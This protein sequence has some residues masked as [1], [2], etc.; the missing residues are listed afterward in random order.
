[1]NPTIFSFDWL[2]LTIHAALNEVMHFVELLGLHEGLEEQKHGMKGFQRVMYGQ[3]GFR[4]GFQ[5][6]ADRDY[7]TL[8]LPGKALDFVGPERL[9]TFYAQLCEAAVGGQLR[10]SVPRVDL[11]FDT[12]GFT[13]DDV[14][15]AR[16][17]DEVQCPAKLYDERVNYDG[18]QKVGH[19]LYF[20]SRTSATMLRVYR[21][22]DGSS[23]FGEAPF[24]RVEL[25]LKE[26]VATLAF[27]QVM[28][29]KMSDWITV[30]GGLL[31]GFFEIASDWW[32]KFVE[33]WPKALLK[34]ARSVSSVARVKEWLYTQVAASLATYLSAVS[35]LD[36]DIINSELAALTMHGLESL[37]PRHRAMIKGYQGAPYAPGY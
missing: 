4:L 21:K 17:A 8:F 32:K 27:M 33:S 25:E 36:H 30:A 23:L 1:M 13:V 16:I 10:W 15:A 20:G 22:V 26:K 18:Q 12:Q 2:T 19:T 28:A 34:V 6:G 5:P 3:A 35:Q 7:C 24:T 11:A 31:S 9:V 29:N 37:K 14:A